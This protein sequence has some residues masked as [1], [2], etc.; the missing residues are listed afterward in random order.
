MKR[1]RQPHRTILRLEALE[2]RYLLSAGALDPTFGSGGTV[3]TSFGKSTEADALVIQPDGKIVAAGSIEIASSTTTG[4]F[5]LARY[6]PDGSLDTGFGSKGEVTTQ[7][8]SRASANAVALQPDGKI[9]EAGMAQTKAGDAIVILRYNSGGSLDKTFGKSG[10]VTTIIAQGSTVW[11]LD[12]VTLNGVTKIL[13]AGDVYLS[14]TSQWVFGLARY[15]LDGSLDTSFGSGGEVVTNIPTQI[16]FGLA[17][18]VQGDGKIVVAGN[19]VV[20]GGRSRDFAL[21]RFNIDGSLDSTFGS[22][23]VVYTAVAGAYGT[24]CEAVAVALQSNGDIVAGGDSNQTGN[25]YEFT[26][27]RYTP[28]GALDPT[29]GSGGIVLTPQGTDLS[30]LAIQPTDGK[31][32]AVGGENVGSGAH[33]SPTLARYN[34]DSSLDA[35]FGNGGIVSP[36]FGQGDTAVALQS[37]GKIVT[38]WANN[39]NFGLAR[40]L[41]SEPEIGSFTASPNPVTTGSSLTLTASSIT[42]ANPNSTITQVAFY[43][44]SNNDGILEPGADTLLGYATQTSPGVWTFTFTVN[45]SPGTYRLF[46]QVEDTYGVFGDPVSLALTVQ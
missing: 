4:Y 19:A 9:L 12:M 3:T 45:L 37:D 44:D 15:N 30:A 2:E 31:I 1:K 22:S 18:L 11:S 10:M 8:G 33:Y 39:G 43:L 24:T 25:S 29:F 36:S 26:L 41:P 46:A 20:G 40:Y 6:N 38:T 28:S 17:S 23:G 14:S 13:A 16:S 21:A 42:D 5:T 27:V 32:I 35:T 7:I 34:P